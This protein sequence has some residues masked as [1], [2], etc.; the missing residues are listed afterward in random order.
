MADL[1]QTADEIEEDVDGIHTLLPQI[2]MGLKDALV[3]GKVD[4]G[5]L[6]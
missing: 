6:A 3:R 1:S 2:F 4:I 5:S